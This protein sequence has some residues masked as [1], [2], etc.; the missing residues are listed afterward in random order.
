MQTETEQ[1]ARGDVAD[2]G[3]RVREMFDR[4][5]RR[6]TL[7]NTLISFGRDAHWRRRAVRAAAVQPGDCLLDCCCGPGELA[8]AFAAGD[9]APAQI[10][11]SDF[12][13]RMLA[14]AER[15]QAGRAKPLRLVQADAMKLSFEASSFDI[16]SCAFGLRNLADPK[17]GLAEFFRVLRPGGRVA[18]LE[19]SLPAG[20]LMRAC[21]LLYFRRVLPVIGGLISGDL[22]AYRYLPKSVES[23]FSPVQI[24]DMVEAVGFRDV[25]QE[26]LSAGIATITTARRVG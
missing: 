8:D 7:V 4:I 16:V 22:G 15:R 25:R 11:A 14:A 9:P 23:F 18:I 2:K 12:S 24:A 6:Y 10:T 5:A 19:F 13:P 20:R 1:I 21:Y 3:R 26:S 17:E